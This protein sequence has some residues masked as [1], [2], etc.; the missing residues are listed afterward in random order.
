MRIELNYNDCN[1]IFVYSSK[2]FGKI[3]YFGEAF[4]INSFKFVVVY[5]MANEMGCCILIFKYRGY[6]GF[7]F[8]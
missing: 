2:F 3:K 6:F 7:F 5:S 4:V 1:V 8:C